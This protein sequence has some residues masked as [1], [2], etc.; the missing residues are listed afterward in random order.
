MC[1]SSFKAFGIEVR[2]EQRAKRRLFAAELTESVSADLSGQVSDQ[3]TEQVTEHFG[4][5]TAQLDLRQSASPD[6]PQAT[7]APTSA[8]SERPDSGR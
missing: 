3:V 1:I 7:E 8:A 6:A 4:T 5:M 2:R